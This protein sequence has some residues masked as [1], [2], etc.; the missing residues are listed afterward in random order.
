MN[1]TLTKSTQLN[2]SEIKKLISDIEAINVVNSQ[3]APSLPTHIHTVKTLCSNWSQNSLPELEISFQLISKLVDDWNNTYFNSLNTLI[4]NSDFD[5][6]KFISILNQVQTEANTAK[7]ST[8]KSSSQTKADDSTL[9]TAIANINSD[10]SLISSK[11]SADQAGLRDL[12]QKIADAQSKIND[13][14]HRQKIYRWIPGWGWLAGAIDKLA[15]N[16]GGYQKQVDAYRNAEVSENNEIQQ[17]QSIIPIL[18]NSSS[19]IK[20]LSSA[21]ISLEETLD[22]LTASLTNILGQV[23]AMKDDQFPVWIEFQVK[24]L[25]D[26]FEQINS[27]S[28][29]ISS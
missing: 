20:I 27:I 16:I 21:F 14:K 17:L 3:A 26:D 1:A 25:N 19:T 15:S 5:K 10:S 12:N 11:L 13:Y 28:S 23:N 4:N 9:S 22:T 6:T 29:K 8:L 18:S 7:A 24:S 2:I